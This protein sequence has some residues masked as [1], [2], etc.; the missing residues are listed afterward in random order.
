MSEELSVESP[1]ISVCTMD[2]MSGLCLGCYR[3]LEEI[4]DW[5]DLDNAQKSKIV[6]EASQRASAVFED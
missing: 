2:E 4:Q 1:C 5:W 3:T 6:D